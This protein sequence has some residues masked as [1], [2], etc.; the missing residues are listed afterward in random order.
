MRPRRGGAGICRLHAA[1]EEGHAHSRGDMSLASER[2]CSEFSGSDMDIDRLDSSLR[3]DD[4]G[5]YFSLSLASMTFKI[6]HE[7]KLGSLNALRRS[8]TVCIG[9]RRSA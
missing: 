8:T 3:A 5:A 7:G 4:G 1:E 6:S 9:D 2:E